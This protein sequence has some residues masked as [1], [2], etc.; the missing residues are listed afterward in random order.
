MSKVRQLNVRLDEDLLVGVRA[1][2]FERGVGV[3]RFVRDCL[4][5]GLGVDPG[6]VDGPVDG[7]LV[8]L[9]VRAWVDPGVGVVSLADRIVEAR[10]LVEGGS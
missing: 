1:E 9:G 2:A 6:V 3:S 7:G 8:G 10:L 4:L 5:V